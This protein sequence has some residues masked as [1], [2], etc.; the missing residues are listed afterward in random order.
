MK[1]FYKTFVIDIKTLKRFIRDLP[2][3]CAQAMRR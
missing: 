2:S 3:A 1:P